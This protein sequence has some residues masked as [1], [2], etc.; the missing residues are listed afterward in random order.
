MAQNN[1]IIINSSKDIRDF[2]QKLTAKTSPSE[3]ADF[4]KILGKKLEV[5]NRHNMSKGLIPATEKLILKIQEIIVSNSDVR[6]RLEAK[7]KLFEVV[8]FVQELS[9]EVE[10]EE[11]LKANFYSGIPNLGLLLGELASYLSV[12]LP[13]AA[14]AS[15]LLN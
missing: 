5:T 8:G 9:L 11:K 6:L 2:T 1:I 4:L 10:L 7:K 3:I 13:M 15:V 12:F 14:T